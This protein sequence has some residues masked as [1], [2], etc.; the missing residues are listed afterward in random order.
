MAKVQLCDEALALGVQWYADNMDAVHRL[1]R[2]LCRR[3]SPGHRQECFEVARDEAI[4]TIPMAMQTYDETR[5]AALATH[6]LG[7]VRWYIW[8]RLVAKFP[9]PDDDKNHCV[10]IGYDEAM[11]HR[12]ERMEAGLGGASSAP[13]NYDMPTTKND[14]QRQLSMRDQVQY[15]MARVPE[16]D[17]QLL[18]WYFLEGMTIDQIADLLYVVK[19]TVS[20]CLQEALEAAQAILSHRDE[21]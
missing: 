19:S 15:A 7:S 21:R 10:G 17:R 18:E 13:K 11:M 2:K 12:D 9:R 8:K 3:T 14:D 6:V 1:C 5:G 4:R 20:R 16:F